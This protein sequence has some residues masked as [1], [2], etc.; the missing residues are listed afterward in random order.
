MG[1]FSDIW[2]D[3]KDVV[4]DPV[5]DL[6]E[7]GYDE[8]IDPL[9]PESVKENPWQAGLS[10]AAAP[11][12]GGQSLWALA[13]YAAE[14][15]GILPEGMGANL[16]TAIL[17]MNA[18]STLGLTL[19]GFGE[20]GMFAPAAESG[21][22]M[23]D[24]WNATNPQYNLLGSSGI[25][26]LP[27]TG[28]IEPF[29]GSLLGST[30]L[31]GLTSGG[32]SMSSLGDA[33]SFLPGFGEG[34]GGDILGSTLSSL[35]SGVSNLLGMGGGGNQNIISSLLGGNSGNGNLLSQLLSMWGGYSQAESAEDAANA[36]IAAWQ[37]FSEPIMNY[38]NSM[39]P[40][41]TKMAESYL[42]Y[43]QQA[44]DTATKQS[45][46]QQNVMP[47]VSS[48]LTENLNAA[49]PQWQQSAISEP[50][51][52][53][54]KALGE[55]AAGAGTLR[56]GAVQDMASRYD[57]AEANALARLPFENKMNLLPYAM[58]YIQSASTPTSVGTIG[59]GNV[60]QRPDEYVENLDFGSI[61]ELIGLG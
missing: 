22:Y 40:I 15:G 36:K 23:S 24:Y 48:F 39:Y 37:Q 7:K 54:R 26:S 20:G 38:M 53:A 29:T 3:I 42:P 60:G 59:I 43:Y 44:L 28:A 14:S 9:L 5:Q 10:I 13:P 55:R 61:G 35:G 57:I 49:V 4:K 6:V 12:S 45:Q 51:Q 17:T 34:F 41:Q 8:I 19:P 27:L 16:A 46:A 18:L 30:A 32:S 47:L 25:Q 1:F 21:S 52:A 58:N 50:F 2:E 33:L 56:S 11:F 31:N